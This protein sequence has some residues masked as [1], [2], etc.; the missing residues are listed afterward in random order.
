MSCACK[1]KAKER[2]DSPG[3]L[4]APGR[5]CGTASPDKETVQALSASIWLPPLLTDNGQ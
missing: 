4:Q 3:K 2:K 1:N 5:E